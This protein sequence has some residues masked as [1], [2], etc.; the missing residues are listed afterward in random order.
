MM[1]KNDG[2]ITI[3]IRVGL[4][5]AKKKTPRVFWTNFVSGSES[6]IL[7]TS[8]KVDISIVQLKMLDNLA[9]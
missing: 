3:Y 2:Y 4:G 5:K 6:L 1:L 9:V 8:E 7:V